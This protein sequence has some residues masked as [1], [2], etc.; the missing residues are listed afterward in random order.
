MW[1]LLSNIVDM[2]VSNGFWE[3]SI[4]SINQQRSTF[5]ELSSDGEYEATEQYAIR[6]YRRFPR[7]GANISDVIPQ[8]RC[9]FI[10]FIR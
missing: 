5:S 9:C 6:R 8:Q 2:R 7:H 4:R 1:P 3:P 10:E